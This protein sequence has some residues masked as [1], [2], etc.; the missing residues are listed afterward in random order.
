MPSQ[1]P[2]KSKRLKI[3][4]NHIVDKVNNYNL[5]LDDF[6]M[7]SDAFNYM[8]NP[9][10]NNEAWIVVRNYDQF[11]DCITKNGLPEIISF[12]HDLAD[13]HYGVQD[14]IDQDFYDL[15]E[16]RT[17]YHCAQWMINY[18]LD[19]NKKL[20]RIIL[21]HSMNTVGAKNIESL[22]KTYLKVHGE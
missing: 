11:V 9:M 3:T 19:N 18:C 10:Y 5:F 14:H 15:C 12:D 8:P 16:E 4:E 13:V 20:P 17:G 2:V 7:P 6:R 22:F 21:I 1:R